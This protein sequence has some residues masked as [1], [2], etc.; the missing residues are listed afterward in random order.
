MKYVD[1]DC[2]DRAIKKLHDKVVISII[3]YIIYVSNSIYN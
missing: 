1:A 3:V 2:L